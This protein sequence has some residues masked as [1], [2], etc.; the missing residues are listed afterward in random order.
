MITRT[1]LLVFACLGSA[2]LPAASKAV[3]IAVPPAV[4][5]VLEA[6]AI[7]VGRIS[8]QRDSMEFSISAVLKGGATPGTKVVVNAALPVY[9]SEFVD[10][11]WRLRGSDLV[12][13]VTDSPVAGEVVPMYGYASAWH[14]HSAAVHIPKHDIASLS[15]FVRYVLEFDAVSNNCEALAERLIHAAR[16]ESVGVAF[17]YL[18]DA[19]PNCFRLAT[20]ERSLLFMALFAVGY[21]QMMQDAYT[22][23]QTVNALGKFPMSTRA[24]ILR[25]F[26]VSPDKKLSQSARAWACRLAGIVRV[27]DVEQMSWESLDAMLAGIEAHNRL[28]DAKAALGAF[29]SDMEVIRTEAGLIMERITGLKV[30]RSQVT[31]PLVAKQHWMGLVQEWEASGRLNR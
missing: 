6:P 3:D 9:T 25:R 29:E 18:N 21:S 26:S 24:H 20:P 28:K 7:L 16:L 2:L 12:L 4:K 14:P 17:A 10:S 8:G 30:D 19:A 5:Q 27:E 23:E 13:L 22:S 31:T 11:M 1:S 15:G